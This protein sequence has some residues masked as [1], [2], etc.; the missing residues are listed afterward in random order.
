[1][2]RPKKKKAEKVD[3]KEFLHFTQSLVM[4]ACIKADIQNEKQ[5]KH[6]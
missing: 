1:M 4:G 5:Q 3:K 6:H 2:N